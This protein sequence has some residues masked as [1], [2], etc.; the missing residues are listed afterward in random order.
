MKIKE[1]VSI[2]YVNLNQSFLAEGLDFVAAKNLIA[3]SIG[4]KAA[5]ADAALITF[6]QNLPVW[7]YLILFRQ[8]IKIFPE[9]AM[10]I[11]PGEF[12]VLRSIYDDLNFIR[13][14]NFHLAKNFINMP[15]LP[16]GAQAIPSITIQLSLFPAIDFTNITESIIAVR[17]LK[18][19]C[20]SMIFGGNLKPVSALFFYA[21]LLPYSQG[22]TYWQNE[23]GSQP[24]SLA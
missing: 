12:F 23:P 9:I 16:D 4:Q 5:A 15:L 7:F 14:A 18:P 8:A 2:N 21:L 24:I 6:E 13:P 10:E 3:Q 17:E 22:G 11:S 20:H 1:P 19:F